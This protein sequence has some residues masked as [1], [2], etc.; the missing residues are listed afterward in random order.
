M[1]YETIEN[2][3]ITN[4]TTEGYEIGRS[5][6]FEHV[7]LMKTTEWDKSSTLINETIN[8]P[9]KSMKAVVLL[10]KTKA[11]AG[12]EEYVYPNIESVKVTDRRRTK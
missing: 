11:P 10:F 1:E 9:R 2:Q 8:L 5:L 3:D 7:T 4:S 6:S 12:S